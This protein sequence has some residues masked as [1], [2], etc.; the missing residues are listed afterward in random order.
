MDTLPTPAPAA[1][2]GAPPPE[3]PVV[4]RTPRGG[5][6]SEVEA[7]GHR[8]VV[9]EP[10]SV[11][12]T[13]AG[14]TPYDFLLAGL[15]ACTGMTLRMY[16][17][18]KGWPLEEV[19]VKLSHGRTHAADCENCQSPQS[20]VDRVDR[21]IQLTGPLDEAQRARLL[22]IANQCP[23]HRTLAAGFQVETR[24]AEPAG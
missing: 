24:L 4:V 2:A 5:F 20:R 1:S 6:R 13:G 9:D 16:A 8:M 11:G 7:G 19:V 3:A 14:P 23:V 12:G 21:E 15:G 18:R 22:Q 17:D 10:A